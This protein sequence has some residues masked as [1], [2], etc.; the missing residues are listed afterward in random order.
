[1]NRHEQ[2]KKIFQLI[3]QIDHDAVDIESTSF[4]DLYMQYDYIKSTVDYYMNHKEQV[5]QNISNHLKKYTLER[6]SKV[7]RNLLRMS[8]SEIELGDAPV[9]VVIN[10]AV[11]LSKLYGDNDSYRFINGVLKNFADENG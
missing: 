5:D 9:R 3:F 2:R 11:K 1:M 7:D 10:E 4:Y 6:I 8:V